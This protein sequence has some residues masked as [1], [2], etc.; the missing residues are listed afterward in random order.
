MHHVFLGLAIDEWGSVVA[1][2]GGVG[3]VIGLI[4][5]MTSI[6][7]KLQNAIDTLNTTLHGLVSDNRDLKRQVNKLEDRFEEHVGEAKVRNTRITNLEKE[8]F[9]NNRGGNNEN[10]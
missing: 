3:G 9:N 4:I 2:L 10:H 7:N 6:M 5:K 1:I 8:V